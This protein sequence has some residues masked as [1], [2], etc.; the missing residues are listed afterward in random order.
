MAG[1]WRSGCVARQKRSAVLK[2]RRSVPGASIARVARGHDVNGNQ[3]LQ[4]RHE[5]RKGA[6]W[7]GKKAGTTSTFGIIR[8]TSVNPRV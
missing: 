5:Y 1:G 6:L 3:V 7:A 4:W 2:R 8:S